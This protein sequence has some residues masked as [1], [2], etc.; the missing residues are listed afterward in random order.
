MMLI[1]FGLV[2]LKYIVEL[3][4]PLI[5]R[6]YVDICTRIYMFDPVGLTENPK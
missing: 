4:A 2:K 5:K 3:S 1:I 6:W